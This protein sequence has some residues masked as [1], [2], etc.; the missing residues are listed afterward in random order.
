[1]KKLMNS[2]L[3]KDA[4]FFISA[5]EKKGH[6][7][8]GEASFSSKR[9]RF[10]QKKQHSLLEEVALSFKR[11]S[12]FSQKKQHSL[13]EETSLSFRRSSTLFKRSSTIF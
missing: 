11:C 5:E 3:E 4:V 7:L 8:S 10:L 1:M 6:S 12:T 9:R 13:P 2:L